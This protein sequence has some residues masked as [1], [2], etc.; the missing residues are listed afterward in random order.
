M[1]NCFI[2]T[3]VF[4]LLHTVLFA[5]HSLKRYE[6]TDVGISI[7]FFSSANKSTQNAGKP[8]EYHEYIY[9]KKEGK[10][11]VFGYMRH[12]PNL[13]CMVVDSLYN[14]LDKFATDLDGKP[15]SFRP[16][17]YSCYTMPLGWTFYNSLLAVDN[18]PDNIT[19]NVQ[20]FYNGNQ[21]L[22]VMVT[23]INENYSIVGNEI[24]NEPGY[25]SILRKVEMPEIG[26]KLK[27]RGHVVCEYVKDS[28]AYFLGRCD[29]WDVKYPYVRFEKITGDPSMN[30]LGELGNQRNIVGF[31]NVRMETIPNEGKLAKF[32]KSITKLISDYKEDAK[33]RLIIYFFSFG[34]NTYSV[35][36]Y[37]IYQ[38]NDNRMLFKQ[39]REFNLETAE[40]MDKRVIE[41]FE[42]LE[43]L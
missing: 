5:Q 2:Y 26:L 11:R 15:K 14:W 42:N 6:F 29:K 4:C 33:G 34:N 16:L 38:P 3:L 43:I 39:D 27:V 8:G 30:A 7:P 28:K 21:L 35:F 17:S 24:F 41:L 9:D 19:R 10:S 25:E 13:G 36:A 37:T 20:A 18:H 32:P 31:D 40:E 1:P 23:Y 22:I 12:Y